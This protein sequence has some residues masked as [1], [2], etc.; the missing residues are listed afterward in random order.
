MT[1]TRVYDTRNPA[2]QGSEV[3]T[4]IPSATVRDVGILGLAGAYPFE[5]KGVVANLTVTNTTQG[6]YLTAYP[7]GTS[8]P[9]ASNLNWSATETRPNLTMVGTDSYGFNSFYNAAGSTDL[10]IDV[11]GWFTR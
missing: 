1:P 2:P 7:A 6:G 3:T 9:L 5:Y 4:P 8:T 11:A 10:I